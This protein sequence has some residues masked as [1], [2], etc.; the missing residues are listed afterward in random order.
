MDTR[1]QPL[2]VEVRNILKSFGALEVLKDVSL[3]VARGQTVS[4][5]GPSGSGKSTL[6]RC[7]N[8]LEEPDSGEIFIAGERIGMRDGKHMSD[9]ELAR[10]RARIGMVFQSFN[11]WPHLTVLQNV[12]EAPIHVLGLKKDEAI[13]RA[14][15]ILDKVGIG[16]KRDAYPYALS[17]G[18]KQRVGIAR[19]LAMNPAVLLFDEPT[20]SLD[21]ELVGEVLAVMR[22]LAE[23]GMTMVVVTHEMDFAREV[24]DEVVFI[25]QG[26]VV[27]RDKP[28]VFF[29]NPKSARARQFLSRYK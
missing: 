15:K 2:A 27:E 5:L 24:S 19:A 17:G 16:D 8:W 9:R 7:I 11:L 25:D 18:Q 3:H 1:P 12:T 29:A 4:I 10:M 21:P 22:T 26:L 23:E 6:L 14:E 13:A 28:E 20:S